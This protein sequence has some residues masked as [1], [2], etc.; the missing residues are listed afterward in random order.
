MTA[1]GLAELSIL[2][3]ERVA[4]WTLHNETIK[5]DSLAWKDNAGWIYAFVTSVRI[6]YIGIATTILRSRMDNY[7]HLADDR[8][9]PLIKATLA[10]GTEVEI[11]G[12]RRRGISKGDLEEEEL[13]LITEF[14]PDWN[15]K[16][17]SQ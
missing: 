5:L 14:K 1:R 8:V 9:R 17:R 3:F 15:V 4:K 6:R 7:A 2:G 16:G 12:V 10:S 11:F 13:G